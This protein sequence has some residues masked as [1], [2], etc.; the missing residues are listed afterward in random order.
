MTIFEGPPVV[1]ETAGGD[2]AAVGSGSTGAFNGT[3]D[4]LQIKYAGTAPAGTK[5][6]VS[7]EDTIVAIVV[8]DI[9]TATDVVHYPVKELESSAGSGLSFYERHRLAGRGLSYAV[10]LSNALADAITIIP[11]I[12]G[13]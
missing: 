4:S 11:T 7:I 5:L 1:I 2:G 9:T 8:L 13:A 3:L 6:V 10:T 12:E